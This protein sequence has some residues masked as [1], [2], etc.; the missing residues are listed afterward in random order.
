MAKYLHN[1]TPD[2]NSDT[3][4]GNQKTEPACGLRD[5]AVRQVGEWLSEAGLDCTTLA[6]TTV[7]MPLSSEDATK[8]GVDPMLIG[9]PACVANLVIFDGNYHGDLEHFIEIEFLSV[10]HLVDDLATAVLAVYDNTADSEYEWNGMSINTDASMSRDPVTDEDIA[11]YEDEL[12]IYEPEMIA[13]NQLEFRI[14]VLR[15]VYHLI[16]MRYLVRYK[17]M[18][19]CV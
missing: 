18:E 8:F 12:I 1:T 7:T 13:R 17:M 6:T 2:E 4:L 5:S 14:Q 11:E 3:S 10:M 15:G 16:T 9:E 19:D